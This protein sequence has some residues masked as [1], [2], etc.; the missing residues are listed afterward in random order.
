MGRGGER[1]A[2]Q[3]GATRCTGQRGIKRCGGGFNTPNCDCKRCNCCYDSANARLVGTASVRAEYYRNFETPGVD[4]PRHVIELEMA[5]N[6]YI[7]NLD[8]ECG[9]FQKTR[10]S[11]P[12]QSGA[13]PGGGII[14]EG[15]TVTIVS[16]TEDGVPMSGADDLSNMGYGV[17]AKKQ[18]IGEDGGCGW[19]FSAFVSFWKSN[20]LGQPILVGA[21]AQ[22][23]TTIDERCLEGSGTTSFQGGGDLSGTAGR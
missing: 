23:F 8:G 3:R 9:H 22:D 15:G 4:P 20:D 18:G 1:C 5:F 12:P 11:T 14:V 17:G 21:S 19:G 6:L 10:D 2:G 16:I 13:G 7:Q